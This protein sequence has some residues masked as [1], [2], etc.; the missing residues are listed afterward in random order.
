MRDCT[1]KLSFARKDK[2]DTAS[3]IETFRNIRSN[4]RPVLRHFFTEK[5][6]VPQAWF[7]MRLNYSRSVAVSSIIGHVL[8]LGDRH[9]SNILLD[10]R[11]GEVVHIDLGIAFEQVNVN[12]SIAI[13]YILNG[14]Q[15]KLLT[16]AERV[17]FRLTA[18]IV[19]GFG[20]S[21]TEGVFRRCAEETLRVLRDGS[22]VIKTVL[23]VFKY[24]PLHSW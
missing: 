22:D 18:D 7:E 12:S 3:L 10:T 8:G 20:M 16:V 11:T 9:I 24:D 21:G 14:S 2:G 1:Y 13:S 5:H 19:D 6:K 4:F 23:E 17:P 15:G